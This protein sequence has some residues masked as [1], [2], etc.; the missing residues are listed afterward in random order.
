MPLTLAFE[1]SM[2]HVSLLC[3]F[4]SDDPRP[5]LSQLKARSSLTSG[6]ILYVCYLLS[7]EA[8]FVILVRYI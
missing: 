1:C 3:F 4:S 6:T 2:A 7:S 8:K 5:T